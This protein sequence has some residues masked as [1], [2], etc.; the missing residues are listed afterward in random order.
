M[1]GEH[2]RLE[3]DRKDVSQCTHEARD[4]NAEIASS[5]S[6]VRNLHP[7]HKSQMRQDLRWREPLQ[8]L[9]VF[10]FMSFGVFEDAIMH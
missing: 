8:S 7:R 6:N 10:E 9:G 4:R 1:Q 3:I 2:L 5:C